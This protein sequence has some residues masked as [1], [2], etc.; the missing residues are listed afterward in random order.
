[1][2]QVRLKDVNLPKLRAVWAVLR[3]HQVAYR[4][5][6]EKGGLALRPEPGLI[7]E[8]TIIGVPPATCPSCGGTVLHDVGPAVTLP[9]PGGLN[10]LEVK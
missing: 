9:L 1:M 7:H 10:N 2:K 5:R 6:I 3:G 4:I 8:V